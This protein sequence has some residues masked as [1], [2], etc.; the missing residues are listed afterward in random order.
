MLFNPLGSEGLPQLI[1]TAHGLTRIK[2]HNR[3]AGGPWEPQD[4]F[5]DLVE[6]HCPLGNPRVPNPRNPMGH[7]GAV[8]GQGGVAG[9]APGGTPGGPR[10]PKGPLG[11]PG[12]PRETQGS[13]KGFCVP[14]GNAGTPSTPPVVLR[15]L[16]WDKGRISSI[17]TKITCVKNAQK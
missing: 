16:W 2:P 1:M 15:P 6:P 13:P 10:H 3:H 9:G 12:E 7:Q 11:T 8:R 4:A 5:G 17:Y 14:F